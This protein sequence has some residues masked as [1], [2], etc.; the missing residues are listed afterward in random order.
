[1]SELTR[2]D[3]VVRRRA[4]EHEAVARRDLASMSFRLGGYQSDKLL[5][6][7]RD[8]L[9]LPEKQKPGFDPGIL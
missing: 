7:W 4:D 1:M 3:A 6:H 8:V 9:S 2:C 5:H